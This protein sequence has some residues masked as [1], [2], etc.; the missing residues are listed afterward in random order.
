MIPEFEKQIEEI[1]SLG[2]PPGDEKEVEKVIEAIR[3]TLDEAQEK[4]VTF[5]RTVNPFA[6]AERTGKAYG[7][8]KCGGLGYN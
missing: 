3:R 2:A 1:S 4:P 8:V 6:K 5:L 7:F